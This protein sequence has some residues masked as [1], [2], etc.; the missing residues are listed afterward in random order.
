MLGE[1]LGLLLV[2]GARR[3]LEELLRQDRRVEGGEARGQDVGSG[4]FRLSDD[5]V[6]AP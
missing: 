4:C 5:R 2:G 1:G 6:R 3:R